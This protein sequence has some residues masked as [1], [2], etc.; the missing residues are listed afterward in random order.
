MTPLQI[1]PYCFNGRKFS[2]KGYSVDGFEKL[3]IPLSFPQN[4]FTLKDL[5]MHANQ[6]KATIDAIV[7]VLQRRL[8]TQFLQKKPVGLILGTGLENVAQELD[9]GKI[10]LKDIPQFPLPLSNPESACLLAGYMEGQAVLA[11]QGRVHLYE[12]YEPKDVV[13]GVRVLRGLG[14]ETLI[15]TNAA[16]ALNPNFQAGDLFCLTDQINFTGVSPLLGPNEDAW[17]V[18]FP[19]MSKIFD[20]QLQRLCHKAARSLDL[21]L[22]RGVYIGVHGPELE[23]PAETRMY[24]SLGADAIGMSSVLEVICAKHLG[25]RILA[26]SCLTNK[27]LPDCMAETSLE[28]VVQVAKKSSARMRSLLHALFFLLTTL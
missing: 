10:P 20:D 28:E 6:N 11:L 17:G 15:V 27:N 22:E 13:L 21:P 26:L 4:S 24:R 3:E 7:A 5:P 14:V 8:D 9:M 19:D 23:S 12:G 16:G 18:R 1:E 2:R 25:M